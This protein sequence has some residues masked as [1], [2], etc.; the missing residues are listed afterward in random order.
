MGYTPTTLANER[1]F[2]NKARLPPAGSCYNGWMASNAVNTR[3]WIARHRVRVNEYQRLWK[4]R[5]QLI[6]KLLFNGFDDVYIKERLEEY[7][8]SSAYIKERALA[9]ERS[10]RALGQQF[11]ASAG[12]NRLA[13]LIREAVRRKAY[14]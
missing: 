8:L 14:L 1:R 11:L 3:L 12:R 5:K 2:P 6:D 4:Q 13:A 9:E 7:R 10:T